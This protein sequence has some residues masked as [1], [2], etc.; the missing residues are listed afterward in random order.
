V[1]LAAPKGDFRLPDPP[2]VKILFITAGSGITPVMGMLRTLK[3]RRQQADIVYIHSA[4]GADAVIFRDELRELESSQTDYR[5]RLQLTDDQSHF[6]F[7]K[8]ADIVPD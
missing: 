3:S 1:R 4:P 5:L 8:L 2:P 7:G 6:D